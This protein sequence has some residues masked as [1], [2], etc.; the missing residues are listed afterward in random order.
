MFDNKY[1]SGHLPSASHPSLGRAGH[2]TQRA[3]RTCCQEPSVHAESNN[4]RSHAE[5]NHYEKVTPRLQE[6]NEFQQRGFS[7][8]PKAIMTEV[9][10]LLFEDRVPISSAHAFQG[11]EDT[12]SF[13]DGP[14]GRRSVC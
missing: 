3:W 11:E 13:S 9:K 10:T 14:A 12:L 6:Q 7:L 8:D 1:K 2:R 5:K 4:N